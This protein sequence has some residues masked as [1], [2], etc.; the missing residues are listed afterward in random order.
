MFETCY[1]Q[2]RNRKFVFLCSHLVEF[3]VKLEVFSAAILNKTQKQMARLGGSLS[4]YHALFMGMSTRRCK[5]QRW[6]GYHV[7][8]QKKNV[9]DRNTIVV[10]YLVTIAEI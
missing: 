1:L 3:R 2:K 6:R 10:T 9:R 5:S 4:Q 8:C 7:L